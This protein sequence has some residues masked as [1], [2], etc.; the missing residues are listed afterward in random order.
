MIPFSYGSIRNESTKNFPLD[1]RSK[2]LIL[3]ISILM[4]KAFSNK[5]SLVSL[6]TSTRTSILKFGSKIS[7]L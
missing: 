2:S 3:I 7:I 5:T 4:R 6:Q 1:N